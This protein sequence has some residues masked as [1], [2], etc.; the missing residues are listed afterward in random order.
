METPW[1]LVALE[2]DVV[3]TKEILAVCSMNLPSLELYVIS[4]LY[5]LRSLAPLDLGHLCCLLP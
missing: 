5:N 4:G 3:K 1:E 2:C